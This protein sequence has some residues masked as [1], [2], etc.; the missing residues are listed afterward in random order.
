[1]DV[2]ALTS[3]THKRTRTDNTTYTDAEVLTELNIALGKVT[4]RIVQK[5]TSFDF[6]G[7]IATADLKDYRGLSEGV[8][9]YNGKYKF[10]ADLLKI[11]RV[12][13]MQN[14]IYQNI[15]EQDVT[16]DAR[17]LTDTHSN[18]FSVFRGIIRISPKPVKDVANGLK[19]WY[20]QRQETLTDATDA[21][22]FEENFHTVIA[23]EAS[24]AYF[25][26]DPTKE[27]VYR[28]KAIEEQLAELYNQLDAFYATKTNRNYKII[29]KYTNYGS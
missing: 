20:E 18:F 2:T 19:I 21:P 27:N 14:S 13:V 16:I 24:R 5:A 29:P 12:E 4:H 17:E 11:V 26:A 7:N 22:A 23:L 1:M 28:K 9:G 8:Q 10:P 6:T 25:I 3:Y 15:Q